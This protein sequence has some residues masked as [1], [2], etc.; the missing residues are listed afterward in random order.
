M[1]IMRA[2]TSNL[3]STSIDYD[4]CIQRKKR[5]IWKTSLCGLGKETDYCVVSTQMRVQVKIDEPMKIDPFNTVL[6][7]KDRNNSDIREELEASD[8]AGFPEVKIDKMYMLLTIR[9]ANHTFGSLLVDIIRVVDFSVF[10]KL[11]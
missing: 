11:G 8:N 7:N 10:Q 1:E 4:G 2:Q 6:G 9:M 3:P 5:K